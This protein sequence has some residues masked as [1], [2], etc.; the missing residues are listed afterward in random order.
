MA[1]IK[2]M[3]STVL[4]IPNRLYNLAVLKYR[5]V[6]Y[7]KSL[8]INGRIKIAG[9]GRIRIGK[10]VVINSSLSSNP[11]GGDTRTVFSLL[12]GAELIIGD[13]VG[14]SNAAVVCHHRVVIG[15]G[16]Q[17]GGSVRIYDTDFHTL[18]AGRR[19]GADMLEA[20]KKP[21]E[22][23]ARAFIGAHSIVLKGA[24]IGE[25]SIVGAGS[26][27]TKRIPDHEIWAGNTARCIRKAQE[28]SEGSV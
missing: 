26:V 8:V 22:I 11:I 6:E 19:S 7:D 17:I 9:H 27:V 4:G 18:D 21:V 24:A 10:N 1:G 15:E 25:E 12:N 2:A 28:G 20:V 23:G 14:I 13:G 5:G 16:A 3:I